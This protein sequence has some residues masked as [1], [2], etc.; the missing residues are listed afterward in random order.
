[1]FLL[2]GTWV[3]SATDLVTALLSAPVSD[4]TRRLLRC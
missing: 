3:A 4:E 1:M 2:D